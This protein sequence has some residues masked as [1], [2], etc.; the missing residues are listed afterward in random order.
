MLDERNKQRQ[1][2]VEFEIFRASTHSGHN[3][4]CPP[5]KKAIFKNSKWFIVIN[6]IQ[7]ILD[8]QQE[9]DRDV[10]FERGNIIR[11]YDDY[12]E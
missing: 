7:D 10:I 2:S 5:S 1:V 4:D 8:L 3:E 11:I 12:I 9:C 6:S